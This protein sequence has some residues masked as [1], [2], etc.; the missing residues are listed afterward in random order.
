MYV[1]MTYVYVDIHIH[2]SL[3]LSL[4]SSNSEI[5]VTLLAI[6]CP[7]NGIQ[8]HCQPLGPERTSAPLESLGPVRS[9]RSRSL[10]R[11][12]PKMEGGHF[13]DLPSATKS[14]IFV[15]YL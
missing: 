11:E 5:K 9:G 3:S 8:R 14:I 4:P 10:T 7:E 6:I 1:C 13:V 12:C 15:G 2:L